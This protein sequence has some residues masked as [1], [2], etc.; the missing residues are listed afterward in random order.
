MDC[1]KFIQLPPK[2]PDA[3][4][5]LFRSSFQS[6]LFSI[7]YSIGRT[8]LYLWSASVRNGHIRR[9]TDEDIGSAALEIAGNNVS[10]TSVT[11]PEQSRQT[12]GI[13]MPFLVLLVKN[14]HKYFCFEVE[15][16]DDT[17]RKRRFK[18]STFNSGTKVGP[19]NCSM[20][21]RL[22]EGWNQVMFNLADFTQ[23][24]YG[25]NYVET[26]RITINANCR[27]RRIFF[28]DRLYASEELPKDFRLE[29]RDKVPL[30]VPASLAA[31]AGQIE[32][33][34]SNLMKDQET[35]IPCSKTRSSPTSTAASESD[36]P[37]SAR[38]PRIS[39]AKRVLQQEGESSPESSRSTQ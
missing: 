36:L 16:L 1:S 39:E 7:F 15:V 10:T 9:I 12:L 24:A 21:L 27:L 38:L 6:G 31:Q 37:H 28:M 23:R 33:T 26:C 35:Y 4:S 3:P 13:K 2:G 8:P 20:P 18:T 17:G 30:A 25:T 22:D 14:L 5:I 34:E 11:C 29:V 19:F 32:L